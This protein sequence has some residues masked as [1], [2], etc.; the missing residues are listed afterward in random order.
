MDYPLSRHTP[1]ASYNSYQLLY[2]CEPILPNSIKEKLAL[3]VDLDDP[4]VWAKCFQEQAQFFLRAMLWLWKICP[5]L[6]TITHC[7]IHAFVVV[8]T[9][10]SC[11][12]SNRGIM[13][14]SK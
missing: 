3:V 13:F 2:E 7:V 1:L 5:L 10:L 8:L 6:S 9:D 4:N 11:G 14:I 12:D